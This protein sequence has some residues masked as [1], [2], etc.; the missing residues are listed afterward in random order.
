MSLRPVNQKSLLGSKKISHSV[1]EHIFNTYTN[2]G[3][4]QIGKKTDI[5]RK[6]GRKFDQGLYKGK[7]TK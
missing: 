1:E 6:K 2:K 4:T 7:I 5:T 3:F